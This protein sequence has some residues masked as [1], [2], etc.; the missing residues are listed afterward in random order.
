M[1]KGGNQEIDSHQK[2]DEW[3]ENHGVDTSKTF[4]QSDRVFLKGLDRMFWT[5]Y[6]KLYIPLFHS[7]QTGTCFSRISKIMTLKSIKRKIQLENFLKSTGKSKQVA[8][9]KT[10]ESQGQ[11]WNKAKHNLFIH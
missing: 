4:P 10:Q 2:L 7:F 1:Y 11:D 8:I 5:R 3:C 9:L 6:T